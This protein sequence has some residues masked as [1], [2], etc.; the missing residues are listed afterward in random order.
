[1]NINIKTVKLKFLHWALVLVNTYK[2]AKF[3]LPSSINY[4]DMEGSRNK[5][6][7]LIS[8]DAP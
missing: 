6:W 2:C 4:G 7:G 5:N 3:Q 1:M 8:P